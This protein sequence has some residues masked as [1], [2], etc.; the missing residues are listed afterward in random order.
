MKLN[1]GLFLQVYGFVTLVL[2]GTVQYFTGIGAVL[3]LPFILASVMF[4]L[5]IMQTSYEQLNLDHKEIALLAIF[6]GFF[7][8][9]LANTVL[10]N[11]I[12]ITIVGL[13]NELALSLILVCMLLGFARES[14]VYRIIKSF[15]LIYYLQ[16]PLILYQVLI[17]VPRRV[18]FKG[19]YEKWDSVVGTFGGDPMGGGNTAAMGLLCLLIMLLKVS[20]YKHGATT[21]K[22]LIF[23]ISSAFVLCIMGEIKFVILLSP[24][25]LA[26]V[27]LSPSYIKGIKSFDLKILLMIVGGIFILITGA[28]MALAMSYTSSIG[29][30]PNKGLFDV[31]FE[32]LSYIFDPNYIMESGE[33]GRMT[34]VFFWL[35]NSDLYGLS[36]SLFGYGLNATN[37]GSSVSPGFLNIVF[38]VLLDSTSLSMLLWEV[39]ILGT[40]L[41]VCIVIY[42]L[43]ISKPKAL[44][45]RQ[46][47]DKQDVELV[48]YQPALRA[49]ILGCLLSLPYSQILMLTPSLQ[50]LFYFTLGTVIVI[51]RSIIKTVG[52]KL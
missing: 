2:C 35:N 37:H 5:L 27:W 17:I 28:I 19:P 42:V 20:E 13:K 6:V 1:T 38:N 51:R 22:S 33:L 49:F 47:L 9:V 10:Q 16:F 21:I 39:G 46:E 36:G 43:K 45:D 23:H 8:M 48:S 44:L 32:S 50:F 25:L 3:W 34:T 30:D 41:F 29:A 4:M 52:M 7:L 12:T 11:G 15:Y 26:M 18:A 14:Q 40:L 31:F 24:I